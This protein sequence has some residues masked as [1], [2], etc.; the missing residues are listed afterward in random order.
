MSRAERRTITVYP[1]TQTE[2]RGIIRGLGAC[3][4]QLVAE[5]SGSGYSGPE[6]RGLTEMAGEGWRVDVI[7]P[8][9]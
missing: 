4:G 9:R 3:G 7:S 8:P 2:R 5:R 1:D 6:A